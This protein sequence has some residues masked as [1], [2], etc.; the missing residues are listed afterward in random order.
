MPGWNFAGSWEVVAEQLPDA[1]AQVQGDRRITWAEFDR[2]ADGIARTLLDAGAERA[3]QGRPVPLQLP[4]VPRVDVRR[5]QGRPGP[6]Q[7]QLPLRRRRAGLPVGQRRRRRRR[8]PR[9]LRRAHRAASAT[10]VPQVQTWLWVDD[11][12]GPCPE[13]GDALRG[14]PPTAHAERVVGAVG[15]RR[16]PPPAA[17]H[18]RHHRHAQGRDVAPGRPVP[19]ARRH[20]STPRSATPSPTCDAHRASAVH[21][22]G[23]GRRCR[24]ARSCT[25]PAAFTPLIVADAGGGCVV[26]LDGP[27]TSTSTSCSTPSSASGSTSIAIVGDAFAKPM[28]RALDAEPGRW[29]LSSL[30]RHH[31]VGR[32]VERA[33]PSRACSRHHPGHDAHRRVLVVGGDR[34]GPV[35]ARP[36]A[37][38]RRPPSSPLGEQRPGDH[39]RRPRRRAGSG[40]IGRVAVGG[41]PAGRVLQGP[42]EVGGHVRR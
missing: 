13:L 26:T 33:G 12:S 37:A 11:G 6:G 1:P 7:H 42:R 29:D 34:H 5:V 21:G 39:R 40:E 9:H 28:L 4:R 25:A 17:L 19:R 8:V 10:G 41:L 23:P 15:P 24:P 32:D 20:A 30:V 31:L 35:G 14:R 18:R 2:R 3:G 22:A 38:R 16:R 27:H 36:R